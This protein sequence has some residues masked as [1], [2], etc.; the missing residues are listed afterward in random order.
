[1]YLITSY[2]KTYPKKPYEIQR[3]DEAK[4]CYKRFHLLRTYL[5]IYQRSTNNATRLHSRNF[6]SSIVIR[7]HYAIY[8]RNIPRNMKKKPCSVPLYTNIILS[9]RGR[10][11]HRQ[12]YQVY[13]SH[14]H[15]L[16]P[17]YTRT[18]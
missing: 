15:V 4:S 12:V 16:S 13:W 18:T 5:P 9:L 11:T 14:R 3:H 6:H 1:M 17:S 10:R 2:I 8:I 7:T